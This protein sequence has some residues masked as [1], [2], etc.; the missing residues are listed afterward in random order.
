MLKEGMW[1]RCLSSP[2]IFF[3]K[4]KIA[5]AVMFFRGG[6]PDDLSDCEPETRT[7]V[8]AVPHLTVV[9]VSP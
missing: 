9:P 8:V 1:F 5:R 3:V 2:L 7:D 6:E 4:R